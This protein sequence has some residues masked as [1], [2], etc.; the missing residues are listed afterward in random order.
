MFANVNVNFEAMEEK[1]LEILR[2]YVNPNDCKNVIQMLL[3]LHIVS[4][5]VCSNCDG[6]GYTLDENGKRKEHCDKC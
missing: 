6:Y 5:S 3:N 2:H 1:Y 4:D